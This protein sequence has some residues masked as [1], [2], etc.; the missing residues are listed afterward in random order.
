MNIDEAFTG[1]EAAIVLIA[2]VVV[3]AV[4]AYVVLGAGFFTTQKSQ[5]VVHSG[6]QQTG[7]TLMVV[8]EVYGVDIAGPS[9]TI[10]AINV[11]LALAPGGIPIDM[12]KAV[13]T[14]SNSSVMETLQETTGGYETQPAPGEW[15]ITLVDHDIGTSNHLLEIGEQFEI[16]AMPSHPIPPDDIITLEI[17]PAV[18]APLEIVRTLP[19]YLNQANVLY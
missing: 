14:Y 13:V 16:S 6:I 8:G 4:F 17:K 3:A 7:S 19:G 1:L 5:E 11:T 2:F 10:N 18:G 12:D 15:A 9:N